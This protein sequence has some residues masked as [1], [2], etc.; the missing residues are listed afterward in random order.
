[1]GTLRGTLAAT[2]ILVLAARSLSIAVAQAESVCSVADD[3]LGKSE[4]QHIVVVQLHRLATSR[5]VERAP[6]ILD[7]EQL[8]LFLRSIGS[9][10]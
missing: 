5:L 1:M 10:R 2:V 7:D 3:A 4:A 6:E 9:D 8:K